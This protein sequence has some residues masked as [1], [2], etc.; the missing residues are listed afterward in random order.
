MTQNTARMIHR[1]R[2]ND[3]RVVVVRRVVHLGRYDRMARFRGA[4]ICK[5]RIGPVSNREVKEHHDSH[6]AVHGDHCLHI[7]I[8]AISILSSDLLRL[9]GGDAK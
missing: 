5:E 2:N 6:A 4:S 3:R 8:T 1:N 9:A 7:G